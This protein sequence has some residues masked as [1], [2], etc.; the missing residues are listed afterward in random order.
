MLLEYRFLDSRLDCLFQILN[1]VFRISSL[2][3]FRRSVTRCILRY[4]SIN[5][6]DIVFVQQV[7]G[8]VFL[9]RFPTAANLSTIP[10]ASNTRI[11]KA[12]TGKNYHGQHKKYIV[13]IQCKTL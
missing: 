8:F 6:K 3:G 4:V 1:I 2:L 13:K 12:A 11:N 5:I 9:P 10:V 7:V